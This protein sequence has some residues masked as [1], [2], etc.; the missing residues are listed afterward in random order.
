M[1]GSRYAAGRRRAKEKGGA[2]RH[3]SFRY[4]CISQLSPLLFLVTAALLFL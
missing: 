1:R 3:R 2:T 4:M